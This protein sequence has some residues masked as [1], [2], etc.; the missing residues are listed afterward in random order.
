[1]MQ[2][3][4]VSVD[5]ALTLCFIVE[6]VI[7]IF[8]WGLLCECRGAYLRDAWN[9]LDLMVTRSSVIHRGDVIRVTSRHS[10]VVSV[11]E[12]SAAAVVVPSRWWWWWWWWRGG[13]QTNTTHPPP[14]LSLLTTR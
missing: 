7:K 5:A 10:R 6:A 8:A 11:G 4:L 12:R 9:A 14:S 13:D 2:R 1:M 3:N